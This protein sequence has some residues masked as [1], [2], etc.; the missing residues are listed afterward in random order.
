MKPNLVFSNQKEKH[1]AKYV[2]LIFN[3]VHVFQ[4]IHLIMPDL[5]KFIWRNNVSRNPNQN[6]IHFER[7][8][9][10][11][12]RADMKIWQK[13]FRLLLQ[14]LMLHSVCKCKQTEWKWQ[15]ITVWIKNEKCEWIARET[16]W[17]QISKREWLKDKSH[18]HK[19]DKWFAFT[20]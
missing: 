8:K 5:M 10:I 11:I 7:K 14:N 4:V 17:W 2:M 19:W 20:K 1:H 9:V 16:G 3:R 12:D 18:E 15:F 13:A 6:T